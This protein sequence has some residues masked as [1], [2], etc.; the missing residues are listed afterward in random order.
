MPG[1]PIG[2]QLHFGAYIVVWMLATTLIFMSAAQVM[3]SGFGEGFF[4]IVFFIWSIAVLVRAIELI[5]ANR[6]RAGTLAF[7]AGLLSFIVLANLAGI[8]VS[9]VIEFFSVLFV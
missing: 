3:E 4:L 8:I 1:N 7:F 9:L 2:E 6:L 5:R